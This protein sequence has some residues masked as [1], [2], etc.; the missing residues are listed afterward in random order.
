MT[1]APS[2]AEICPLKGRPIRR[3]FRNKKPSA[4]PALRA[5]ICFTPR[6]MGPTLLGRLSAEAEALAEMPHREVVH[7]SP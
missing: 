4:S 2:G 1:L 6:L 3:G 5:P 7:P